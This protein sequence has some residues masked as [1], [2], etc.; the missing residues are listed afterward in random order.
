[1]HILEAV[2]GYKIYDY[3]TYC[4]YRFRVRRLKWVGE[5][6]LDRSIAHAW[7]SLDNMSFSSQY[8]YTVSLAACG[9]LF[10][11]F[12]F[13]AMLRNA[14]NPFADPVLLF[15]AGGLT[16]LVAPIRALL[17]AGGNY[18]KL[19]E[20]P[21]APSSRVDVA[22]LNRLDHANNVKALVRSI[23]TNPFRHKF[24]RVN[25]E[26][27][28]HNIA[29]I[30]GGKNY[31]SRAGPALQ[32][33]QAI[34]QRAVNAEA[35]D[36]R[37]RQ[38]QAKIAEDLAQMPYNA[39]AQAR[40]RGVTSHAA[41]VIVSEDSVSDL[42]APSWQIPAGLALDHVPRLARLWLAFARQTMRLK[43]MVADLVAKQLTPQCQRCR[44][45]F[46]LQ[47]IQKVGFPQVCEKFRAEAQ[48]LPFSVER[49]RRFY[50]RRQVF[51]TLCME[52]AYLDNLSAAHVVERDGA[53]Q[54]LMAENALKNVGAHDQYVARRL[55]LAH[56]RAIIH[57]WLWRARSSL[58]HRAGRAA[59]AA[60]R[61]F[62][63]QQRLEA[64]RDRAR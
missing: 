29:L 52:C 59:Q 42:L 37:L 28:I 38:E 34:Y 25:R 4:D 32:Y 9:I 61:A 23:Q 60:R 51:M 33:L 11:Y 36:L 56:V 27:L 31:L 14:Y 39:R 5:C 63:E 57:K 50:L 20:I 10:L 26:W 7:R 41:Q 53:L 24:M 19:W 46:R 17:R 49:W 40:R 30:L 3:F 2:H 8:Y 12:G 48:G 21:P 47:V 54:R 16:G 1:M 44:S 13:T 58:L 43:A 6:E 55:G 18:C 64:A 15:Y 62:K 22:A 35:I 45:V